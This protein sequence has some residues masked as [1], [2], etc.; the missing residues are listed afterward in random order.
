MD[1]I[2]YEALAVRAFDQPYDAE[3]R[4]ALRVCG[5]ALEQAGDP[6]GHLIALEHALLDERSPR[7]ARELRRAIEEHAFGP[8]AALLGPLA[9]PAT[10]REE[11]ALEW[12]AGR[13]YGA[14]VDARYLGR[15]GASIGQSIGPVGLVELVLQAPAARD[16]RRL[17]VRTSGGGQGERR[18]MLRKRRPRPPLE[19]IELNGG[20]RPQWTY[21]LDRWGSVLEQFPGL[22]LLSV[23]GVIRRLPPTAGD[24]RPE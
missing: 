15:R 14:T 10:Y 3:L 17:R 6:R 18:G 7:R 8:G 21:P 16:L 2:V 19:E 20:V 5:D 23:H 1:A 11:V 24:R 9:S 12:R 13:I 22:Y 4:A